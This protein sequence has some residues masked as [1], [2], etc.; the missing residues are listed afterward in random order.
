ME[1]YT[2]KPSLAE[3]LGM[4]LIGAASLV[5]CEKEPVNPSLLE[6]KVV[7]AQ[8]EELDLSTPEKTVS[9]FKTYLKSIDF[10]I[11]KEDFLDGIKPFSTDYYCQRHAKVWENVHVPPPTKEDVDRFKKTKWMINNVSYSDKN[12]AIVN[13]KYE[14]PDGK[15]EGED[16]HLVFDGKRWLINRD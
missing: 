15:K 13:L 12:M 1:R 3:Y 16:F 9:Q 7:L 8:E 5:G 4:T 2:P 6:N 11:I 10:P 14:F